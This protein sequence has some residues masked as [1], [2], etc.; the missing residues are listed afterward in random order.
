MQVLEV[1]ST[2]TL[3]ELKKVAIALYLFHRIKRLEICVIPQRVK[4]QS[5]TV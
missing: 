2:Y 1:L 4:K 3:F 5:Y